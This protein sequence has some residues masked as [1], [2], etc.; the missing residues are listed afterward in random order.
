MEEYNSGDDLFIMQ[1]TFKVNTQVTVDSGDS[2][3]LDVGKDDNLLDFSNQKNN[4][5]VLPDEPEDEFSNDFPDVSKNCLV[6]HSF[7]MIMGL[8]LCLYLNMLFMLLI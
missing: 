4:S 7:I 2:L 1:N 8:M 3:W 6:T 5:F